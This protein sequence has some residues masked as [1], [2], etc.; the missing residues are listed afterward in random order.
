MD[1]GTCTR[2]SLLAGGAAMLAAAARIPHAGAA[3]TAERAKLKVSYEFRYL[4]YVP[5]GYG[6]DRSRKW[7]LL[8]FLHGAGE[9]HGI[10]PDW[11]IDI[12]VAMSVSR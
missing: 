7:P 5:D 3:Q 2:R 9:R 10:A 11:Q 8:L 4:S 6:K 1:K 12:A